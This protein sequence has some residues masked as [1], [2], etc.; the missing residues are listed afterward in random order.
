M[1]RRQF[2]QTTAGT[3]ALAGLSGCLADPAEASFTYQPT[4][5]DPGEPIVFDASGSEGDTYYWTFE[6][7]EGDTLRRQG[8]KVTIEP[9]EAGAFITTLKVTSHGPTSQAPICGSLTC[10]KEK[11][12][13]RVYVQSDSADTVDQDQIQIDTDRVNILLKGDT[14]SISLDETGYIQFNAANLIGN[15]KL[16]IQL[17]LETHS[18]I[19]VSS[20]AFTESGGG[21]YTS[22]FVLEPGESR[23]LRIGITAN[24]PG[25]HTVVGHAIYYFGDESDETEIQ[26]GQVEIVATS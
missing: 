7:S 9:D 1:D 26:S 5:P 20:T 4:N 8:Q 19:S 25:Q 15:K 11:T 12:T 10:N 3:S 13:K 24:K 16:T 23:G 17:I 18:G 14:T 6:D 21:Q 22:T 2:L